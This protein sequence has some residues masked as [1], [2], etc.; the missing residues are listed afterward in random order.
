[1]KVSVLSDNSSQNGLKHEWGLSFHIEFNGRRFL[2]DAGSSNLYLENAEKMG[3]DISKVNCAILSH[4][5][6]DHAK[7]FPAF[8]KANYKAILHLSAYASENCYAHKAFFNKYIGIPKG[9]LKKYPDRIIRHSG[10]SRVEDGVFLVAHMTNG[11]EEIGKENHLLVRGKYGYQ[12][13]D[14]SHELTLVFKTAEGLVLFNSCSHAGPKVIL[15]ETR[16]AFPGEKILAY[17]GGLHLHH[18]H[19]DRIKE[20]AGQLDESGI[21][22]IYTGHCT[23]NHGFVILKEILGERVEHFSAGTEI[24]I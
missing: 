6:F 15:A 18:L 5:H 10:V 8:F 17:F 7:G 14:F 23:G 1:M 20:I 4:A 13:D 21:P 11:L 24:T 16:R 9:L 3:I 12:P 2:L 19:D 22:H